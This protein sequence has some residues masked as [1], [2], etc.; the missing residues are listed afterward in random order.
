MKRLNKK[1][2]KIIKL[3]FNVLHRFMKRNKIKDIK[4]IIYMNNI[5]IEYDKKIKLILVG[6]SN[7]G[8]TTFFNKLRDEPYSNPTSTIG[9]DFMAINREYKEEK[10]KICLWDT[11]GQEKFK[12]I[13]NTYF[14]EASGIILMFDLSEYSS[15][16]NLQNWLNML[17]YENKC[18]HEH[19]ILLIGNKS[20]KKNIIPNQELE[21][22][23]QKENVIYKETSCLTVDKKCLENLIDLLLEKILNLNGI[24]KGVVKYNEKEE[25]IIQKG[26][27][28]N[29]KKGCCQFI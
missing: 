17:A 16:I 28:E 15:Y 6:D 4:Y 18:S 1:K 24:C 5:F 3:M 8:K 13:V 12:S 9:V 11:A 20:D 25:K 19:P 14:R 21:Q 26:K 27:E 22:F 2:L 10:M 29:Q 7:V 23:K